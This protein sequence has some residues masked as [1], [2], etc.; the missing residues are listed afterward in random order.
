MSRTLCATI[1]LAS[2]TFSTALAQT[3]ADEVRAWVRAQWAAADSPLD[4]IAGNMID[5][6]LWEAPKL[7][8]EQI[9]ELE[10]LVEGKPDHPA[11][12]EIATG[13]RQL[14]SGGDVRRYRVWANSSTEF[15]ISEDTPY[16]EA[17]YIDVARAAGVRWM[18]VPVQLQVGDEGSGP[19]ININPYVGSLLNYF[20]FGGLNRGRAIELKLEEIEVG[21]MSWIAMARSKK[22]GL[23]SRF[24]GRWDP[25]AGRGFVE[26][27][28][29]LKCPAMPEAVGEERRFDNWARSEQLGEWLAGTIEERTKDGV[30]KIR[31]TLDGVTPYTPA[32]FEALTRVP[33]VDG[34]DPVRGV[35]TY[36]SVY[37]YRPGA[38][39]M[40]QRRGEDQTV[41][42]IA[43]V[44]AESSIW[45]RYTGWGVLSIAIVVLVA[46]RLRR[47]QIA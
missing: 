12:R 41:P 7:T 33:S 38:S 30:V 5:F 1:L 18:M 25:V 37:D 17:L 34:E 29:T 46:L 45:L 9:A 32:E 4:G 24:S 36:K 8:K 21:G 16:V 6:R 43:P 11:R 19:G 2:L 44:P 10:K 26:R 35:T 40:S 15:R 27:S 28:V 13:K 14:A 23:E 31:Y 42:V 47:T 22:T 39:A 3:N 20:R